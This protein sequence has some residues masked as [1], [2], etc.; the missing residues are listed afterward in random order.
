MQRNIGQTKNKG[1]LSIKLT[2]SGPN[3]GHKINKQIL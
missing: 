2:L 3:K 1:N